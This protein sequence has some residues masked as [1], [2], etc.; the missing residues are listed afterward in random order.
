MP[1]L[2]HYAHKNNVQIRANGIFQNSKT[3]EQLNHISED[4]L[5]WNL[6]KFCDFIYLFF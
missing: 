2:H 1:F 5:F 6:H 4:I 3:I